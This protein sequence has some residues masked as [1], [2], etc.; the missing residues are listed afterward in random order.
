ML[1]SLHFQQGWAWH[2][3]CNKSI[4]LIHISNPS[5]EHWTVLERVFRSLRDT[6]GYYLT[7]TEYPDVIEGYSDANWVTDFHSVK[8][9]TRYVFMFDFVTMSW[10]SFKQTMIVRSTIESELIA[11]DTTYLEAEWL[12][13]FLSEFYIMPRLILS[14]SVHTDSRST[15]EILKK[16]NT[17]RR[18]TDIFRSGSS[19]YNAYWTKLWF[20]TLWSLRRILLTYWLRIFLRVWF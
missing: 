1:T 9:T 6:I 7:Y 8:S 3:L 17:N 20:W 12:K 11:L 2:L 13:D 5:R 15:I 4:K 16:E 18:W 19:L 10:K 14:I